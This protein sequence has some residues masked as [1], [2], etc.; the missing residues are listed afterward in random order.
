M[1]SSLQT[2]QAITQYGVKESMT[3]NWLFAI[4]WSIDRNVR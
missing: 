2:R 4:A 1:R 3:G